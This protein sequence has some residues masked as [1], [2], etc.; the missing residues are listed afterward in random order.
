[1][2]AAGTVETVSATVVRISLHLPLSAVIRRA[3]GGEYMGLVHMALGGDPC[4]HL[5]EHGPT[6]PG[7]PGDARVDFAHYP[8]AF[9]A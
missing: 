5:E 9:L 3:L 7:D 4:C 2:T 8:N 1:M 6:C